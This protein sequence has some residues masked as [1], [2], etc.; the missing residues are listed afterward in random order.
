[1]QN[2]PALPSNKVKDRSAPMSGTCPP[3]PQLPSGIEKVGKKSLF[4]F[5]VG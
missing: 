4:F 1:M 3:Q 5:G 2:H